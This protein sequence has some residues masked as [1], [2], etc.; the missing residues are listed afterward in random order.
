MNKFVN[1]L[2]LGLCVF[3]ISYLCIPSI[4]LPKLPVGAVLS[5]EPADTEYVY[6]RAYFTDFNREEIVFFYKSEFRKTYIIGR[7]FFPLRLNYPP[8][9]AQTII[10]DQT[11]STFLEEITYPL[12]DS[13]YINGFEPKVA[14]D[15]VWYKGVHYRQKITVRYV[16]GSLFLRLMVGLGV[17]IFS[18]LMC[19]QWMGLFSKRIKL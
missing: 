18:W 19:W 6:R 8:E 3:F 9:A 16:P 5:D 13:I 4:G 15:E 10:R 7:L 1:I 11:R 12:R 2:F 14:K 17:I